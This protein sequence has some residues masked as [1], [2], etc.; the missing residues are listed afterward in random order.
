[1]VELIFT[2]MHTIHLHRAF[3]NGPALPGTPLHVKTCYYKEY[4]PKQERGTRQSGSIGG[5]QLLVV[6]EF[7][8][9]V[10]LGTQGTY[11][12]PRNCIYQ[13]FILRITLLKESIHPEP[14]EHPKNNP[15]FWA[16][17][18]LWHRV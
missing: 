13:A 18:L 14:R 15:E 6:Q 11:Y 8:F 4:V 7:G 1:M 17:V 12:P 5:L 2:Y 16:L 3:E 10:Y 9:G